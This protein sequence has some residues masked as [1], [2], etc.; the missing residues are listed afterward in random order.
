MG[1]KRT[2]VLA[3]IVGSRTLVQ[4][5]RSPMD[6]YKITG[7]VVG[8][9]EKLILLHLV[10]DQVMQLNGYVCV[11]CS[12]VKHIR[13]YSED[14]DFMSRVLPLLG[15]APVPQPDLDIT[16][17][18]SLLS[19]ARDR[20]A[21]LGIENERADPNA[22]FIGAVESLSSKTLILRQIDTAGHWMEPSEFRLKDITKVVL[23]DGYQ[24]SLSLLVRHEAEV[25]DR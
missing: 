16:G 7:Y 22:I 4:I 18:F 25:E 19:S 3:E 11:R 17:I 15:A 2:E 1:N 20:F 6:R 8:L 12:D 23:G 10:Q 21:V 24:A 14:K 5:D 9:S 13:V